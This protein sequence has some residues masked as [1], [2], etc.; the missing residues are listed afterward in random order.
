MMTLNSLTE[1]II[2]VYLCTHITAQNMPPFP[3]SYDL[4]LLELLMAMTNIYIFLNIP[5]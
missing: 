1:D 2:V 3:I 4:N 5:E